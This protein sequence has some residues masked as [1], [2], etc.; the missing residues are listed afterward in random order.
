MITSIKHSLL[1]LNSALIIQCPRVMVKEYGTLTELH[2]KVQI[3]FEEQGQHSRTGTA[4][5]KS[6]LWKWVCLVL[7]R[8]VDFRVVLYVYLL[9]KI[10]VNV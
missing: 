10:N 8:Q 3:I 5:K 4:L 1:S 9:A 7:G 6:K 2:L